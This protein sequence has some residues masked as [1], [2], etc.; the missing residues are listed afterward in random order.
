VRSQAMLSEQVI[1][2]LLIGRSRLDEFINFCYRALKSHREGRA[3]VARLDSAESVASTLDV[4]FAFS[5]RIRPYNKYLTWELGEH[6]L[7]GAEWQL[8]ASSALRKRTSGW[9]RDCSP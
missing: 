4:V 8:R 9:Q 7:L 2:D 6:P 3:E 5:G 1:Q